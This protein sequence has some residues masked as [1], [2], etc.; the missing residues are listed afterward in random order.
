M[1]GKIFISYRRGDDPGFALALYHRLEQSFPLKDLFM[2]VEGGI[3]VGHDFVRVL[4]EQVG[5]CDVLLALIGPSWLNATDDAGRR[6]L[7]NSDDFVR[8]EIE[9]AL[10]LG[11]HV[12][13]VLVN[14]AEMPR[15]D[16]LPETLGPL[17]R[18]QAPRLTL[19]RFK[20]DADGLVKAVES[21]LRDRT[22]RR[23]KPSIAHLF[24]Q[25]VDAVPVGRYLLS[26]VALIVTLWLTETYID[27][28]RYFGYRLSLPENAWITTLLRR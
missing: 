26:I 4:E 11:K 14:R 10:R 5:G 17:A 6:R 21:A 3:P 20:A 19:E 2:D 8:L 13:P 28:L 18:L 16:Y 24:T 12:I 1:V 23:A 7:D 15:A 25:F 9:S 27:I 22:R